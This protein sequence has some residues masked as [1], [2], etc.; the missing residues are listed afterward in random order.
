MSNTL[1]TCSDVS[2]T[3]QEGELTTHVLKGVSFEIEKGELVAIVG[4]SGWGK[5]PCCTFW[6]HWIP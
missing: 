5:A 1:L 3:Y 4:A 6:A 2:K